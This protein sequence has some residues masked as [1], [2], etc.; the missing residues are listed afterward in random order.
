MSSTAETKKPTIV[1]TFT[2]TSEGKADI[3]FADVRAEEEKAV[4]IKKELEKHGK[5]EATV[6][7]GKQTFKV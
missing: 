1:C 4:A 3:S 6:L 5:V 7:I 2:I